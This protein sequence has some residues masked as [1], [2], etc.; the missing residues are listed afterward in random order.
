MA[1][2]VFAFMLHKDGK[3]DDSAPGAGGRRPEDGARRVAR[4]DR[5][6]RGGRRWTACA[7]RLA[8]AYPEV[9][10]FAGDALAYPNAEIIRPLLL[11]VLPKGVRAAAAAH[12]LRDGPGAGAGG[13]DGRG[14]SCRTWWRSTGWTARRSRRCA[15]SSTARP[16]RTSPATSPRAR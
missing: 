15:R 14:L 1:A 11:K 7:R 12:H 5:D 9:W 13:Q 4:R 2:Q 3:A 10:K 16:A 6:R 8:A